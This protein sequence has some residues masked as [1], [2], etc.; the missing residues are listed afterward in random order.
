[1]AWRRVGRNGNPADGYSITN[2]SLTLIVPHRKGKGAANKASVEAAIAYLNREHPAHTEPKRRCA[3]CQAPM[4][5]HAKYFINSDGR[6][7]H[8][9]CERPEEY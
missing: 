6:L 3:A 4:G 9:H 2:G 7:Q 8:R 1:M 5:R